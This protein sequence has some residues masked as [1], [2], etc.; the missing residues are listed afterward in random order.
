M[1]SIYLLNL[2]FRKNRSENIVEYGSWQR[3]TF[4]KIY[5]AKSG[6]LRVVWKSTLFIIFIVFICQKF[7]TIPLL[8]E[9]YNNAI[10][11]SKPQDSFISWEIQGLEGARNER[12]SS[13]RFLSLSQVT[14][15]RARATS[16]AHLCKA[17]DCGSTSDLRGC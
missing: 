3:S 10:V 6:T 4:K 5:H 16:R 13:P 17:P 7:S 2:T 15:V 12:N 1:T 11:T 9:K 8:I 14:L